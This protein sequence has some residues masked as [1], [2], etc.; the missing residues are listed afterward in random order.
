MSARLALRAKQGEPAAVGA[1]A[2]SSRSSATSRRR[3]TR[4]AACDLKLLN[5]LGVG[6]ALAERHAGFVRD[7]L[8]LLKDDFATLDDV[9][10]QL[11]FTSRT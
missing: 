7:R 6:A 9:E 2:A 1:P 5:P 11:R 4:R 10:R 8:A 3:S